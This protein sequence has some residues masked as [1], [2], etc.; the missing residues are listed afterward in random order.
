MDRTTDLEKRLIRFSVMIIK[1]TNFIKETKAGNHLS[2]QIIRS[3]TSP[4]LNYGET[5]SAESKRDFI[6]K[7]SIVLKELRETNIALQI[8]E[9]SDLCDNTDLL[10]E[11]LKENDE[12]ISIF[13]KSVDTSVKKYSTYQN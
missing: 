4:S 11:V 13:V 5:R 2:G 10:L 1:L 7:L 12:L 9:Q 8:I 3:G 6:H